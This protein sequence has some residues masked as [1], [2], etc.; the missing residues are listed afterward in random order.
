ML[1]NNPCRANRTNWRPWTLCSGLVLSAFFNV[2]AAILVV[3]NNHD[4][5]PGSFRQA[6]LD[7]T[8]G[9]DTILF[10]ISGTGV[11]TISVLSALPPLTH[12][13]IING[14]SEPGFAGKPII[15]IN[16]A[17]AGRSTG[18]RI[19]ASGCT[20]R[21][22]IINR[23]G[24][25][26]IE[27]SGA[28]TNIIQGNFIGTDAAGTGDK[29]NGGEGIFVYGSSGNLI[30]G[31]NP[32]IRN[33]I[34]GNGDAGI[35]L[36]DASGN[37]IQGNYIGVNATGAAS[38]SNTNGVVVY[39]SPGNVI[40]GAVRGAG[41]V[42]SGNLG[43]GAYL[44]GGGSVG[45]RLL[46]NRIGTDASGSLRVGNLSDGITVSGAPANFIG[47]T[48]AGEGNLISGNGGGGVFLDGAAI[49][50]TSIQG[51]F[52]GTDISGTS[53]LGNSLAGI[54]LRGASANLIGGS[55]S[56]ARNLISGNAQ[57]GILLS[58]NSSANLIE[59]NYIGVD[60]SGTR[61]LGNGLHGVVID[62]ASL[63]MVGG[64]TASYRNLISGNAGHGIEVA[65]SA[66]TNRVE[67]NYIGTDVTGSCS[68][69][70][71]FCGVRLE[72]EGN[73][74]GG[75]A[76][77][78]QNLISG[79]VQEGVWIVGPYARGN[80]V[81]GNF[82]GV[83]ATG[84][85]P[86]GNGIAGVGISDASANLVGG[87]APGAG[88]LISTNGN[89]G[90]FIL[91]I[92]DGSDASANRIEGNRLGTDI[93]GTLPLGNNYEGVYLQDAVSNYIG[94]VEPG[95]GNLM[96][97]GNTRG[98]FLVNSSWNI[99]QGNWIG[100]QS[101]GASPLGNRF[102]G[103]ECEAGS[104]NN[105]IGGEQEGA[106][107]RLAF[108]ETVYA[109]VRIRANAF[110]NAILGN[111]IFSNGALGI[112]LGDYGVL[113]VHSCGLV[114][115]ANDSQNYPVLSQAFC[116]NGA[117]VS[118][119]LTGLPGIYRLQFFANAVCDPSGYGEGQTLV[120]ESVV[121]IQSGCKAAFVAPLTGPATAGS[122]LTATATDSANNTSEFSA[123]IPVAPWPTLTALASAPGQLLISWSQP[124]Q[125]DSTPPPGSPVLVLL[126]SP[127]LSPPVWTTVTNNVVSESGQFS[128]TLPIGS[129]QQFFE[130]GFQ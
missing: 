119:I 124:G 129:G 29:P 21:G 126:Q 22:L 121:T 84:T 76:A 116:G 30:G 59:G 94:G 61:R 14:S 78:S 54:T 4:S 97:G 107:N 36:M 103:V 50:N 127:S 56:T 100:L 75:A 18:L 102:H 31:A 52:I 60:A 27:I 120:G 86:L 44:Y 37:V 67:G 108:A 26:G 125:T 117:V 55:V 57:N 45:N 8:N 46:G 62:S 92:G 83:D 106:G 42:I 16:G 23:F 104:D 80:V 32:A 71:V 122:F 99:I 111:S 79:N 53:A 33:V 91:G 43:S 77:G 89:A 66:P 63:N 64:P 95:A 28:G 81:Q 48:N 38:L 110:N 1:K 128:V 65:A 82:I 70:N 49:T 41:N 2:Q 68:L 85:K 113:P 90:I 35:Y 19:V 109:G 130:L 96:G 74:V 13:V 98:I 9:T 87:A 20:V 58:T 93:T 105:L 40:G 123:G 101:D 73:V 10:R 12:P 118:G 7:A 25:H 39:D 51:N 11:Q 47:G 17:K 69:S 3:T 112:D 115:G 114:T 24:G 72:S 5:G 34:S 88:N 6:L 15:Q